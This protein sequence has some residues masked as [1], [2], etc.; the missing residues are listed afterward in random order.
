MK[1]RTLGRTGIQVSPYCLRAM[2]FGPLG[3]ADHDDAIRIIHKALDAG[4][5][6]IDTADAYSRGESEAIVG[7]ALKRPAR[8][9]HARH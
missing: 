9:D 1:Y 8:P 3:N 5:N 7:K 2:M 6:F 4:I